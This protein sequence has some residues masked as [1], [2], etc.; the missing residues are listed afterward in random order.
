M[1]IANLAITYPAA[2]QIIY[3]ISIIA[4]ICHLEFLKS[5]VVKLPELSV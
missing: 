1:V 2:T 5:K 3:G 4:E